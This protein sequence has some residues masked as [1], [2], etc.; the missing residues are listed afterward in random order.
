[1]SR[2][3]KPLVSLA[4]RRLVVLAVIWAVTALVCGAAVWIALVLR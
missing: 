2:W 4:L 1:M 3:A